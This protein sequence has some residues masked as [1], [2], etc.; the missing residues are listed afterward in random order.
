MKQKLA[1]QELRGAFLFCSE[2]SQ[3]PMVLAAVTRTQSHFLGL[4]ICTL[5]LNQTSGN[6]EE[7]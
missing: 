3:R 4:L 6:E 5:I 7:L 2:V 1:P